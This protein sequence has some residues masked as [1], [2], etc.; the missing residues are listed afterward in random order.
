MPFAAWFLFKM[1]LVSSV[2]S[3]KMNHRAEKYWINDVP[4][5]I[6]SHYFNQD[7]DGPEEETDFC[8]LYFLIIDMLDVSYKLQY[9]T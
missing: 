2:R 5:L 6:H 1:S 8:Y 7:E 4:F 9:V 3:L